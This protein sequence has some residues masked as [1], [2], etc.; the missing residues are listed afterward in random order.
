MHADGRVYGCI[1]DFASMDNCNN[2]DV[3]EIW[4]GE[5][6]KLMREAMFNYDMLP[7]KCK[8][9][10]K[11]ARYSNL[12]DYISFLREYGIDM[13]TVV[14][15][16]NFLPP[17]EM[18]EDEIMQRRIVFQDKIE[19]EKIEMKKLKVNSAEYWNYRFEN[20]WNDFGGEHQTRFFANNACALMP[21]WLVDDISMNKYTV[22]DMGCAEGDAV[23]ILRKVFKT[24]VI[25]M[26]FANSAIKNARRKYPDY[27]FVEGDITNLEP[28][29][30]TDVV[31]CSGIFE[32]F[33]E[34]W[35]VFEQLE[36][37]TKKYIIILAPFREKLEIEEHL[38]IF[39]NENIMVDGNRFGLVYTDTIDTFGV[40][41]SY[42]PGE[43]ILLVY[44]KDKC[45]KLG[46]LVIG[47][48]NTVRREC[49]EE[50]RQEQKR[51]EK[52]NDILRKQ[53]SETN[54]QLEQSRREVQS[55]KGSLLKKESELADALQMIQIK[56]R[57]VSEELNKCEELKK[58]L[59][60]TAEKVE[61]QENLMFLAKNECFRYNTR[62]AYKVL[63]VI[64]RFQDQLLK[65]S[66]EDKKNFWRLFTS[67]IS[68]KTV[69]GTRTDGFNP[70]YNI[71]NI[72]DG[73]EY[74]GRSSIA[75]TGEKAKQGNAI[76]EL[77]L[78][79]TA[80]EMLRKKYDKA[81][82]II[83]SVINYDFRYQRP[84]H[85]AARFAA[86]GH[87]VFYIN[88]NFST[89]DQMKEISD[90]L[91][92]I[93]FFS[94]RHSAIYET[95][96]G[97]KMRWLTGKLDSLVEKYAIR[98][99][100]VIVDYPNWIYGAAYLKNKYGF[101]TITDYMDDFTGFLG[102]TTNMLKENCIKLLKQSDLVVA[103]SQFLYDIA[104][105]YA[106]KVEI[107]R[108]G[109]EGEHFYKALELEYHKER[110]VIGYYG[111]VAHWFAWEKICYLAEHLPEC[112]IVIIGEVTEHREKLEGHPNI[113]L[114][115]EM[116]YAK[117]PEHLAYFDVCLIPFDTSTDLIKATNPVK[118]YEYLSAGKR[119]VATEIPELEPFRNEYV[120]MSN[121]DEKFLEYV[122]LCL[123]GEDT[124]KDKNTCVAFAKENDWQKRFESFKEACFESMPKISIIVLTYNN[125]ELSKTCIK[126]ILDN[127]AYPD[128]ELIIVDNL[129]EG[130][131]LDYLKEVE[132]WEDKRIKVIYNK[133]NKGFAG[134]NNIGMQYATGDYIMLLNN[135]TVVTRG[136]LT[137]MVK[138][139]QKNPGY[140]MCGA[141]TNSIGNEAKICV[142]Y[143]NYKELMEFAFAYTQK[144]MGEEFLEVD[145]LALFCT[146]IPR[147][148]IEKC[149]YL[150]ERYK[151]G[152]FE[153]DD[154]AWAV[155]KKG[156]KLVIAEDAFV[157]HV[158]NA[159]FKKLDK[160]DYNEIFE[161]NKKLFEEKWN[162]KWKM[163]KYRKGVDWN[164]NKKV[165]I[166]F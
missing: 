55:V 38:S 150:D 56:T 110:K 139:L 52:E 42:Y 64:F 29:F 160:G 129:S 14:I 26:D 59:Q 6:F 19:R 90:G 87:R 111:A 88:A 164:S 10:R 158:N 25:G 33:E 135:D 31:F 18:V 147:E 67:K 92:V 138:H 99:A 119:V 153:D 152:M 105:K 74:G 63:R 128:Y 70:M 121:E 117:L 165:D 82:I 81:D 61:F 79:G 102:T 149:G 89:N 1:G 112:D 5:N 23:G 142:S 34:P 62:A 8:A 27:E 57:E 11:Y 75:D 12:R 122:R 4:N 45:R 36:K 161:Q 85:F 141:V 159:S 20:N 93:D 60:K 143:N 50:H 133:E 140:G 71:I 136:W 37:V 2:K 28:G 118:F 151:I 100:M 13:R 54:E 95:D 17:E 41:D 44:A 146:L 154:Y 137:N 49:D 48:E 156:Y 109:T 47:A 148:I 21:Q 40:E 144:H 77:Q 22:C 107:I 68:G 114:L 101:T 132:K 162:V 69:T 39:N 115:G 86:N 3:D 15:P 131:T 103:S 24:E 94:K 145:R 120:Y 78:N 35:K 30:E 80:K 65:G 163:C 46:Q 157:H 126:S 123:N 83:F 7:E 73:V 124:L 76:Q 53:L 16:P 91:F 58:K 155:K 98:D 51:I 106:K 66:K 127:T 72:L 32:L 97:Q 96:W 125:L 113:K 43:Q 116:P 130:D 166:S 9:C 134:G 104:I 84:Q 108:N